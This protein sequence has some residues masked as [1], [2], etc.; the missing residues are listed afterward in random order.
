MI[1]S[2]VL[3]NLL[4]LATRIAA[5]IPTQAFNGYN[6]PKPSVPFNHGYVYSTPSCPLSLPSTSYV[7]VAVTETR[8][9]M[10]T[11]PPVISTDFVTL[12]PLTEYLTQTQ[13]QVQ[14]L[15]LTSTDY[16]TST[17]TEFRIQP[18]TVTSYITSSYCAPSTYLPPVPPT[19]TYLPAATPPPTPSNVYLPVNQPRQQPQYVEQ[20]TPNS[21]LQS[22]GFAQAGPIKR[23][24][25]DI[26]A[27]SLDEPLG[28]NND[29]SSSSSEQ[30]QANI[31]APPTTSNPPP[32]INIIYLD[33]GESA[34]GGNATAPP[35]DLMNWL[36]CRF[37][38]VSKTC[39]N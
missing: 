21:F 22:F 37:S 38:L 6:Y 12:P 34:A 7:T 32:A 9:V 16:L 10:T 30:S 8:I 28:Q 3:G 36:L 4:L 27:N 13:T 18:T 11:L 15:T 31:A 35:A 39:L 26:E 14:T 24:A 25:N 23:M 5:E 29:Q 1:T 17:T 20:T 2:L 19:N 33:R